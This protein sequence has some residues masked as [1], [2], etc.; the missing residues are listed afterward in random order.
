MNAA[1]SNSAAAPQRMGRFHTDNWPTLLRKVVLF[2]GAKVDR[3]E[4]VSRLTK[5]GVLPDDTSD[6]FERVHAHLKRDMDRRTTRLIASATIT[7]ILT[8]IQAT[9]F[10]GFM[11]NGDESVSKDVA[12]VLDVLALCAAVWSL[13]SGLQYVFLHFTDPLDRA[14][15]ATESPLVDLCKVYE[16]VHDY[17]AK[18]TVIGIS[19][20]ISGILLIFSTVSLALPYASHIVSAAW[21]LVF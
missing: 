14:I 10:V 5:A 12:V 2:K 7:G 17:N 16:Y 13:I 3:E 20:A 21:S 1:T 6:R 9:V 4:T 18:A 15:A 8:A 11:L 19:Q